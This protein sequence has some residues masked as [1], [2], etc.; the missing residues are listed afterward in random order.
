M[1]DFK[2]EELLGLMGEMGL[3]VGNCACGCGEMVIEG[4]GRKFKNETH[5]NR[6]WRRVERGTVKPRKLKIEDD[7]HL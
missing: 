1:E 2:V 4:R 7:I 6:Q 5:K 3:T